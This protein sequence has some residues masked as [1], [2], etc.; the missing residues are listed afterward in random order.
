MKL[1]GCNALGAKII[2]F[3]FGPDICSY[4]PLVK[5]CGFCKCCHFLSSN[6]WIS[7]KPYICNALSVTE[8]FCFAEAEP[9]LFHRRP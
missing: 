8:S 3:G 9:G 7:M 4:L 1:S 5:F 2:P 6:E